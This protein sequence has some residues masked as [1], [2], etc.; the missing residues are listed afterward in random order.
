MTQSARPRNTELYMISGESPESMAFSDIRELVIPALRKEIEFLL[1]D[2]AGFPEIC[3][4]SLNGKA[5]NILERAQ[6]ICGDMKEMTGY[7]MNNSV[8]ILREEIHLIRVELQSYKINK[9]TT[10]K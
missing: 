9:E 2:N 4:P 7:E 6:A 1:T 3:R 10:L 8:K 5:N